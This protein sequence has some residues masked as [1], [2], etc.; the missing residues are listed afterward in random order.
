VMVVGKKSIK[1][2]LE[3]KTVVRKMYCRRRSPQGT[4]P[5]GTSKRGNEFAT[6][7]S[8]AT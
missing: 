8:V 7:Y 1:G 4:V 6:T 5:K 3:I 2:L